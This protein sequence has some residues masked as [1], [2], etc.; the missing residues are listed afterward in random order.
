MPATPDRRQLGAAA[1]AAA[2]AH[3]EAAGLRPLAHNVNYRFGELDRVM[4]DGDTVVFVEVRY[5]RDDRFGGAAGSVDFRKRRRLI[6]AA[7]AWLAAQRGFAD[8]PCRFD[9]VTVQG[10]DDAL[11]CEWIRDAFRLDDA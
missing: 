8:A 6:L 3:L 4:R 11:D 9:V 1:E 7:R 2:C 5:R 10:A